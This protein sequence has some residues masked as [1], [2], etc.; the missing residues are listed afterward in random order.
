[1]EK[2]IKREEEL[3]EGEGKEGKGRRRNEKRRRQR[4]RRRDNRCNNP[5][6]A[7]L[8]QLRCLRPVWL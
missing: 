8:L 5:S 1:M 4:R 3:E 6:F 2:G 7:Y